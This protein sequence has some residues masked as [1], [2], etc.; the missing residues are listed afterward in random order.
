MFEEGR[1]YRRCELHL[2]YGGQEQGGISTPAKYPVVFLFTGDSGE[3]Y[4]YR[5]H[6]DDNKVLHYTGEGQ[7]GDMV[8]VRGNK[9]VRD[10]VTNSEE[11]HRFNILGIGNVRCEGA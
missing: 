11:L 8:F 2:H 3:P 4:G 1:I 10:R 7:V 9:A 5:D 6:W